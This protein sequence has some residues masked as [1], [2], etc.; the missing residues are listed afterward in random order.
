MRP[1]PTER[2][3]NLLA[4]Y[5]SWESHQ[6]GPCPVCGAEVRLLT[7][8]EYGWER[9]ALTAKDYEPPKRFGA[10]HSWFDHKMAGITPVG[11]SR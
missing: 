11:Y 3:Q 10:L 5:H 4:E 8:E 1:Q 6:F 7:P 9:V 2:E